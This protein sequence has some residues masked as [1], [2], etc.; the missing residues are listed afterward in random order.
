MFL[1]LQG[2]LGLTIEGNEIRFKHPLLPDFIEEMWIKNFEIKRGKVDLYLKNYGNDV[3]INIIN[4]EGEVK[5][6]V[7]K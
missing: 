5:V 3:G 1:I 2:C 4:K 6:L 7:E